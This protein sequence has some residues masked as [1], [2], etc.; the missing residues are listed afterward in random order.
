MNEPVRGSA[1]DHQE[2]AKEAKLDWDHPDV[3]RRLVTRLVCAMNI[4]QEAYQIKRDRPRQRFDGVF[5]NPGSAFAWG[6]LVLGVFR[7]LGEIE[8]TGR[9]HE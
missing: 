5:L 9:S 1:W 7:E 3:K 4:V 2:I 6:S 8:E